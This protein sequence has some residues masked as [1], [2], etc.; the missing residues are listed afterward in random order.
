MPRP[1]GAIARTAAAP[2]EDVESLRGRTWV[3][4]RDVHVD[5]IAS[6]WLIHRYLDPA[7][8]LVRAG[9]GLRAGAG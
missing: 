1:E 2:G 5:R 9:Q 7:A 4:R 3:T 8:Q 6:A